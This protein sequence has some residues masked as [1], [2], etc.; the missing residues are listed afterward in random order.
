MLNTKLNLVL[1]LLLIFASTAS[2]AQDT[3]TDSASTNDVVQA[4][5][6]L[7]E[8]LL[9]ADTPEE[10]EAAKA[11][12]V[13]AGVPADVVTTTV[14]T[15][16]NVSPSSPTAA[17]PTASAVAQAKAKAEA[18]AAVAKAEADAAKAELDAAVA[19]AKA[20][21]A[22]AQAKAE[23]DAAVAKAKAE[24]TDVTPDTNNEVT[25]VDVSTTAFSASSESV[26]GS[27]TASANSIPAGGTNIGD[28]GST[29][30]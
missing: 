14:A 25:P 3:S 22:A 28:T 30:N 19:Q 9:E 21:I 15:T 10:I 29:Y 13:A 16:L 24:A 6:T 5:L 11:K 1:S 7:Q 23:A 18:D 20:E 2:V 26:G 27:T 17:P 12:A 8:E 4:V